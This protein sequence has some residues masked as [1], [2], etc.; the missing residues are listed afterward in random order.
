[1]DLFE[2]SSRTTR[3]LF[4]MFVWGG[5]NTTSF[6]GGKCKANLSQTSFELLKV[7]IL[8]R[9]ANFLPHSCLHGLLT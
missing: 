2:A 1:M 4:T 9:R 5:E 7:T 6:S 3:W 8:L